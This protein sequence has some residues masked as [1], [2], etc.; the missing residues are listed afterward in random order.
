MLEGEAIL[1]SMIRLI[2]SVIAVLV[3]ALFRSRRELIVD[4]LARSFKSLMINF[5]YKAHLPNSPLS[6]PSPSSNV[7]QKPYSAWELRPEKLNFS[8]R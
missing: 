3:R 7:Q 8:K 1:A 6:S 4:Q 2:V 5:L